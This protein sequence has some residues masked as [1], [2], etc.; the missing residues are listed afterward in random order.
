M[1]FLS[2]DNQQCEVIKQ[3][4]LLD[5]DTTDTDSDTNGVNYSS[6]SSVAIKSTNDK[7]IVEVVE[8]ALAIL[9]VNAPCKLINTVR[10]N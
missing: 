1:F 2:V 6:H 8:T 9:R 3:P 10:R 7:V 5:E 4:N